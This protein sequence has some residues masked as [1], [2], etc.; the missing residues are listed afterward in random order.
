MVKSGIIDPVKVVRTAL[1]DAA[2]V[3]GLLVTT[4]A[5]VAEKP[6]KKAPPACRRAAAWA[7]T[8][9]SKSSRL[10]TIRKGRGAIPGLFLCSR[11]CSR[12]AQLLTR[13]GD[14]LPP[15]S[16]KGV[17]IHRTACCCC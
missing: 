7:A 9:T 5:M 16:V 10:Q 8:W 4:E 13:L 1:Q 15:I 12:D 6:E 17:L 3:A 11:T 2:S 14:D